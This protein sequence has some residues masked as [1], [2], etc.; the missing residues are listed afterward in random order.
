MNITLK[1]L[2]KIVAICFLIIFSEKIRLG[3]SCE[4]SADD[5]HEMSNPIFF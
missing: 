3:V 4:S 5:L 2:D 1:A